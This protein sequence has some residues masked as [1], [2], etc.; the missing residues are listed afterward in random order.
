MDLSRARVKVIERVN[1]SDSGCWEWKLKIRPDGY[2][3]VT[4][5]RQSFYAHR[6]SFEAFNGYI[7][8]LLDVCH[9]CD[10]RKCVNPNHLFQG[11]RKDNMQDAVNKGRQAKGADL[12]QTKIHGSDLEHVLYM[13]KSGVKYK[14]I[15]DR[16]NVTP[17]NIGKIAIKNNI[18]RNKSCI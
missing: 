2:A 12:P 10:N 11:T 18:R 7:D 8:P 15:A 1:I 17:Q 16:Y 5:L 9:S 13:I 6:L 4:Y 14:D 3:R